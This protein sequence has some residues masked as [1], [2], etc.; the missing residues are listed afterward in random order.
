MISYIKSKV[1]NFWN[2]GHE[3]TLKVKR[4]I[5][6]S[7]L[8]KGASV[9]LG[10]II[11]PLTI[12]YV[13]KG[14]Y[15]VWLTISS[16]VS[17]INTFDVGLS[18][19]LRNKMARSLALNEKDNIVQYVSTTYAIL[20][21]IS[22]ITFIAFYIV[23]SFFNW[24]QLLNTGSAVEFNIW[25]I[26]VITMASFC[27]QFMLQ[28]IKS[29]LTAMHQPFITSFILLIIQ[30]LTFIFTFLLTVFTPSSLMNL[31]LVVAGA[32]VLVFI[33]ANLYLFG[34][35]LKEYRPRYSSVDMS[36]AKSL[37]GTGSVFFFI[38]IGAMILFQTDN[39]IITRT[40]GPQEVTTF[41][42]A[43]KYFSVITM[44]F[45]IIL[46]P[47]WSAFT[48][49]WAKNDTTWIKHSINKMRRIWIFTSMG[50]VLLY[51]LSPIGYRLWIGNTVVIPKIVSLTMAI[52]AIIYNWQG[53]YAYALNGIGKLK[54]QLIGIV[55]A[56]VIN[57]PLSIILIRVMGSV[58][59]TVVANILLGLVLNVLY[60]HQ[61]KLI[62]NKK[63]TGIWNK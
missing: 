60:T 63:A 9:L 2:G 22:V 7:F 25:P 12:H 37:L 20:A 58:A 33:V 59:G 21:I 27:V 56:G 36:S 49:A 31:V 29:M 30:A 8:I 62:V 38:Q 42:L 6:Y 19:G 44:L 24:N 15:G 26:I 3:R 13:N 53:I 34:G 46:T 10:L 4:N 57:I 61:I 11:I 39:I 52:Y 55:L 14:Q 18:N 48:D 43:F 41:N 28:P 50:T 45:V 17:W 51:F 54:L 35:S 40:L 5:I 47:Y 23:G 1:E 16:L 32:P